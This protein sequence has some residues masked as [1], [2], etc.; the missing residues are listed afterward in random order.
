MAP[1]QLSEEQFQEFLKNLE[2]L[3]E[4]DRLSVLENKV[5][6]IRGEMPSLR[7]VRNIVFTG[8]GTALGTL[9]IAVLALVIRKG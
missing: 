9:L 1:T 8:V 6:E 7:I 2:R 3:K 5:D 4:L